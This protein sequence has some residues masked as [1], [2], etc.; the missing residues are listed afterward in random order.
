MLYLKMVLAF[1]QAMYHKFPQIPT[2]SHIGHSFTLPKNS[3][4]AYV[5]ACFLGVI[6]VSLSS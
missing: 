5:E 3:K 2:N 1:Q 6:D 4:K